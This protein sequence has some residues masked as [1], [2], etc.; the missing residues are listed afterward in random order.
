MKSINADV[1]KAL[2]PNGVLI[3]VG[4]GTTAKAENG[5]ASDAEKKGQ[6]KKFLGIF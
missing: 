3:N 5:K 4:R 6:K 1:L 2:G